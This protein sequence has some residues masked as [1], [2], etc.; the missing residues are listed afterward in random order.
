VLAVAL[1]VSPLPSVN[2]PTVIFDA[3]V[4]AES[5]LFVPEFWPLK[6]QPANVTWAFKCPLSNAI[7]ASN[8]THFPSFRIGPASFKN[9]LSCPE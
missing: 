4:F 6:S 3:V 5:G 2:P 1:S 8:P 7:T 9:R